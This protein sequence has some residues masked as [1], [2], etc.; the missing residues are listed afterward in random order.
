MGMNQVRDRYESINKR[1]FRQAMMN[2]LEQEYKILG[3]RKIIELLTED[4]RNLNTDEIE[5]IAKNIN[6]SAKITNKLLEDRLM[7]ARTQQ[8]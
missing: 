2:L 7:W 3:S 8:G 6:K 4:I 1:N 5:E